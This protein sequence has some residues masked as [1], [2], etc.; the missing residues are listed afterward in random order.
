MLLFSELNIPIKLQNIINALSIITK[1][2]R[3]LLM[4]LLLA[5]WFTYSGLMLW[6][7]KQQTNWNALVCKAAQGI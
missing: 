7:L 6:Q 4:W 5:I 3:S 1:R 2:M